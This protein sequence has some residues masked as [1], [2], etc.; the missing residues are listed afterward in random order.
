MDVWTCIWM[1]RV[2]RASR[3]TFTG[4]AGWRCGQVTLPKPGMGGR[5]QVASPMLGL[6]GRGKSHTILSDL[7]RFCSILYDFI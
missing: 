5:G 2:G 6:V 4:S 1:S 7:I 3:T